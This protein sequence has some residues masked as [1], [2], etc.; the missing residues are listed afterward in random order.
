MRSCR[1]CP[2]RE[3][4]HW[5][6]SA[7]A[8]PRQVSVLLH[9]LVVG[10]APLLWRDWSRRAHRHACRQLVRPQHREVSLPPLAAAS[11]GK[12]D[13]ILSRAQR[14]HARLSWAERLARNARA[15]TAS[16]VTS[17]LFGIPEAFATSLGW[18][19]VSLG[20]DSRWVPSSRTSL[21]AS[22]CGASWSLF[23]A[24]SH[25]FPAS[26]F[27]A[28]QPA[29]SAISHGLNVRF[30]MTFALQLND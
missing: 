24:G 25:F 26:A 13:M 9:P 7:P 12:A 16:Q 22:P 28:L 19:T 23:P 6:G 5:K 3:Q 4:C 18:A 10:S 20:L 17:R 8:K 2:L 29:A 1:P 21:L 15:P 30:C 14:A 27:F 11:P